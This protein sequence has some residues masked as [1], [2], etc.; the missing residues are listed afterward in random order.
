MRCGS[1]HSS[2]LINKIFNRESFI[3]ESLLSYSLIDHCKVVGD[4]M[5]S[6]LKSL[7]VSFIVII[8]VCFNFVSFQKQ[9]AL[10]IKNI[11]FFVDWKSFDLVLM[12]DCQM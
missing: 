9:L 4:S 10:T 12:F 2:K 11:R 3:K 7:S 1:W 6:I 5:S 8:I